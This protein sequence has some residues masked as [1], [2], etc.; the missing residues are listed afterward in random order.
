MNMNE[1]Q[2]YLVEEAVEDYE[3]GRLSRREALKA[4]AGITGAAL[5]ARGKGR[6]RRARRGLALA[7]RR[8]C[9]ARVRR[10]SRGPRQGGSRTPRAGFQERPRVCEIAALGARRPRRNDRLLLRRGSDLAR[11]GGRAGPAGRGAFL[12]R[13]RSGR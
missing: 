2:R 8:D 10:D 7:R 11:R 5:A 12:R 9:E 3:E 6:L 4:I 13:T 1:L